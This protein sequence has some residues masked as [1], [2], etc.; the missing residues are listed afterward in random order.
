MNKYLSIKIGICDYLIDVHGNTWKD[1]GLPVS[2]MT[3]WKQTGKPVVFRLHIFEFMKAGNDDVRV[4]SEFAFYSGKKVTVD[5][6]GKTYHPG[7]SDLE[8]IKL[9][10]SLETET[11]L[12]LLES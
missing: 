5:F 7:N 3:T 4:F 10:E 6:M 1:S 9:H 12:A 11:T 8:L 2:S